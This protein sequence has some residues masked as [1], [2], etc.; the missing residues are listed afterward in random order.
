MKILK[1]N[2]IWCPGCLVMRP[3]WNKIIIDYPE[4]ELVEYDYNS[5]PEEVKLWNI[6][7]KLPVAIVLD[8]EG[9]ELTRIIGEKNKKQ[10]VEIIEE[11]VGK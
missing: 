3:I 4:L 2:A 6:G 5:N 1:F 9:K 10:L 8:L 7:N 11:L